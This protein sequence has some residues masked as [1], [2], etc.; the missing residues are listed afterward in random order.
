MKSLLIGPGATGV[1]HVGAGLA[2]EAPHYAAR[3]LPAVWIE[4]LDDV[5]VAAADRVAHY[6]DQQVIHACLSDRDGQQVPFNVTDDGR[7]GHGSSSLLPLAS[8]CQRF[9][10]VQLARQTELETVTLA[11]L[12]HTLPGGWTAPLNH[13]VVDVQ[14]AELLVLR[15]AEPILHHFDSLLVEA[16]QEELYAGQVL[17]DEL[18]TWLKHRH[19]SVAEKDTSRPAWHTDVLF[20]RNRYA[21]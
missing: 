2:Q 12:W 8:H 6:P 10:H 1:L 19:F 3:R 20:L 21:P 18:R 14:G 16:S 13:L 4:A 17:F 9:P 5:A 11:T 15:G 7:G